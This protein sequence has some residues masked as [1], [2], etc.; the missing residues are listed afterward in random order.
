MEPHPTVRQNDGTFTV[1]LTTRSGSIRLMPGFATEQEAKAWAVQIDR[2]F[3]TLDPRL[4]TAS[5]DKRE[6]E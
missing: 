4:P 2:L 6:A 1:H 3:H 5:R